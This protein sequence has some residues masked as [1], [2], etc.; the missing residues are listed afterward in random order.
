MSAEGLLD[1]VKLLIRAGTYDDAIFQLKQCIDMLEQEKLK[2]RASMNAKTPA[3]AKKPGKP[4][5]PSTK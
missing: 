3:T 2:L 4:V 5:L 1:A